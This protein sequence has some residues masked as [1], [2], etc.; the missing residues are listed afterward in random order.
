MWLAIRLENNLWHNPIIFFVIK[1]RMNSEPETYCYN[2]EK[3]GAGADWKTI[4]VS[5][6]FIRSWL[7]STYI[8][9][10]IDILTFQSFVAELISIAASAFSTGK[11]YKCIHVCCSF[12]LNKWSDQ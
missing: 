2:K 7:L 6:L 4:I 9:Y 5:T 12:Q 11:D 10:F 3:A 8:K 1:L